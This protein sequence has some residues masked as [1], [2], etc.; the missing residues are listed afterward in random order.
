MPS[1]TTDLM[2]ISDLLFTYDTLI[3]YVNDPRQIHHIKYFLLCFEAFW[4]LKT[5][6]GSVR[7]VPIA[8]PEVE[9]FSPYPWL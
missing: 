1:N 9:H 4:A 8:V 7:L 5:N 3:F 6:L 2:M